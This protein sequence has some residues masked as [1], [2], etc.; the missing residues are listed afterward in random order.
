VPTVE[1]LTAVAV[2]GAILW[3]VPGP[4]LLLLLTRGVDL[5]IRGAVATAVGLSA[6]TSVHVL[7][8]AA[9]L[10]ALLTASA[11]AFTAVKVLGAA[12]LIWLG[13][14]RIRDRTPLL[15][16]SEVAPVSR[17]GRALLEGF[18][19]NALNPKVAVF[20][21]A[22]LPPF[23]DP[24][25]GAVSSQL[26]ILGLT[27]ALVLLVGDLVFAAL[28]GSLGRAWVRRL[29]ATGP[30]QRLG[31]FLVGGVYVGLGVT[32][33]VSGGRGPATKTA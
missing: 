33:L 14:K 32:T 4:A 10:S 25:A 9:G 22:F 7:A 30:V 11:T 3:T 12:Y 16:T 5:G 26:A 15:P 2:A 18:T 24:A 23:I 20:F 29:S 31:R 1:S 19:I 8:A 6:G 21:V 17:P 28:T 27:V 13:I